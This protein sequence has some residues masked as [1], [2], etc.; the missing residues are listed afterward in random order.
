MRFTLPF[1][2]ESLNCQVM[3]KPSTNSCRGLIRLSIK[4]RKADETGLLSRSANGS[5]LGGTCPT[6]ELPPT[7]G[8][9]E[10]LSANNGYECPLRFVTGH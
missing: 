2:L 8:L 4:Q 10:H 1:R 7:P 9:A 5:K 6:P 3:E